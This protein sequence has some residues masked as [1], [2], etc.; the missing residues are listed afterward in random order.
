VKQ[1]DNKQSCREQQR[2]AIAN[3]EQSSRAARTKQQRSGESVPPSRMTTKHIHDSLRPFPA[4]KVSVQ[5]AEAL[6]RFCSDSKVN[7][8]HKTLAMS[9]SK[10]T[11]KET[12]ATTG[13]TG[14]TKTKIKEQR[15][16]EN[17]KVFK[18]LLHNSRKIHKLKSRMRTLCKTEVPSGKWASNELYETRK[19]IAQLRPKEL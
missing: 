3:K 8:L 14:T 10:A 16:D 1:S 17:G 5:Q 9:K 7:L 11:L 4:L 15:Q 12:T 6:E 13:T 19:A 2:T 18:P